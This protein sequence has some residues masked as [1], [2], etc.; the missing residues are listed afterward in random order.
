VKFTPDGGR[1]SLRSR[2]DE[3]ELVLYVEDTGVGIA[4]D[5]L[6]KLGRP[7]AQVDSPLENGNKG[8]GLGLAIARSLI[9]LHGGA[10]TLRSSLGA[11]T[12]VRIRLPINMARPA[13]NDLRVAS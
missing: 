4:P 5:I 1:I 3:D 11:G 9:E 12:I 2:V 7:F 6:P 10:L 13:Q 8:S